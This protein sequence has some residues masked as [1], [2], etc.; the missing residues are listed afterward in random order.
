MKI[1]ELNDDD[2]L[3]LLM[4]SEYETNFSPNETKFL[5]TKWRY[6]Y[7]LLKGR[8]ESDILK[9]NGEK[10]ELEE[11]IYIL[12]EE[13]NS[14]KKNVKKIETKYEFLVKRKLSIYERITGKIKIE[15]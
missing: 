9:V 12:N 5:L 14:L 8:S 2:I 15:E 1:E 7:R 3:D 11:N 6:F 13:I 4:T 10:T